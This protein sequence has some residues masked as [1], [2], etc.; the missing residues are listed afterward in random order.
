MNGTVLNGSHRLPGYFEWWYF[1]FATPDGTAINLVLHETDILGLNHNPYLSLC[2]F[3]PGNKPQYLRQELCNADIFREQSYLQVGAQTICETENVITLN[4]SFPDRGYFR[5]KITKLALPLNFCESILFED[6]VTNRHSH[7]SVQV[8]H[9]TF[10]AVLEIDGVTQYLTGVAYQDHQ[11]GTLL[12]QEFVS[13]WVWGHFS[14]ENM[15]V[16][17]FHILTQNGQSIERAGVIG[18]TSFFSDT[19]LDSTHLDKL[20][21]ESTPKE[22]KDTISISFLNG[23][24]QTQFEIIPT[25]IMRGRLNENHGQVQASYLRWSAKAEYQAGRSEQSLYGITEYI[26]FRPAIYGQLSQSEHH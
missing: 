23:A 5:G 18:R 2:V 10:S 13:D 7:W 6:K 16:V 12:I 3:L 17:F 14:N 4:I 22:F 20:Y 25:N 21:Q 19:A 15:A 24:I 26:R 11:W 9:A 1:H 8:P